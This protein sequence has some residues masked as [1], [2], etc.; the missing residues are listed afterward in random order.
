[1]RGWGSRIAELPST[2]TKLLRNLVDDML[3]KLTFLSVYQRV[4]DIQIRTS[5]KCR[6][7]WL[8][9]PP[10][11]K[12]DPLFHSDSGVSLFRIPCAILEPDAF[13][14]RIPA[15]G[16]TPES[17]QYSAAID[18]TLPPIRRFSRK[19]REAHSTRSQPRHSAPFESSSPSHST[20]GRFHRFEARRCCR[21]FARQPVL[22]S[23]LSGSLRT[24]RVAVRQIL[25]SASR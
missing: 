23:P 20:A 19:D 24:R 14:K 2:V 5:I 9:A 21:A 13:R 10:Q 17:G 25:P 11:P 22:N 4:R 7:R 15:E 3:R 1:M 12:Q 18:A 16:P 8:R 6:S